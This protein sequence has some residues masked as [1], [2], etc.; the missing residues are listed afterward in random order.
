LL[1]QFGAQQQNISAIKTIYTGKNYNIKLYIQ[2]TEGPKMAPGS[3]FV[4][5]PGF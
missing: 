2:M 3:E 1:E 5:R 4:A